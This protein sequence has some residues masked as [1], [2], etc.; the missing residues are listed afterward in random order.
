MACGGAIDRNVTLECGHEPYCG[1]CLE[2][3]LTITLNDKNPQLLVCP[4]TDCRRAI[5]PSTL[6]RL[7]AISSADLL[8]LQ[9]L[10]QPTTAA[11]FV[12]TVDHDD[13]GDLTILLLREMAATGQWCRCTCGYVIERSQ[14]CSHMHCRCGR[15][16]CYICNSDL[17]NSNRYTCPNHA[18][19]YAP[20]TPAA[21]MVPAAIV[22]PPILIAPQ[23]PRCFIGPGC[24]YCGRTRP[25]RRRHWTNLEQH[26]RDVHG[27]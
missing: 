1:E 2:Q 19:D 21:P 15:H 27:R 9:G 20:A 24:P 17:N 25:R 10:S 22:A 7:L 16:F 13:S 5:S 26:I 11:S 18:N 12:R 8:S 23:A 6:S 3:I 4:E 14:G